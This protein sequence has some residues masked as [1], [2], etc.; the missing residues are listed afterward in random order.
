MQEADTEIIFSS[1]ASSAS[2]TDGEEEEEEERIVREDEE[3]PRRGK[4]P[5]PVEYTEDD[6][7]RKR[8]YKT[9]VKGVVKAIDKNAVRANSEWFLMVRNPKDAPNEF[10]FCSRNW[11]HAPVYLDVL[12]T[13][14]IK[15]P[16][17]MPNFEAL[18]KYTQSSSPETNESPPTIV[19]K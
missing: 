5:V 9:A 6:A 15:N 19:N 16:D 18:K 12:Q 17:A 1:S 11:K 13:M 14:G 4:R 7:K 2:S 3:A 8:M 10:V